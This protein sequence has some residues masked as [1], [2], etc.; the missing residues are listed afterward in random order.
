MIQIRLEIWVE[1]SCSKM[2]ISD[3]QKFDSV[4][5]VFV[6]DAKTRARLCVLANRLVKAYNAIN[7]ILAKLT[8]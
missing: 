4:L 5:P 6:E 3:I 2:K 7:K 8:K 1:D